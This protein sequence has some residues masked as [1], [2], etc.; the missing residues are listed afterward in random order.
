MFQT[1][2]CDHKFYLLKI[3]NWSAWL[4]VSLWKIQLKPLICSDILLILYYSCYDLNLQ[5][6]SLYL[7]FFFFFQNSCCEQYCIYLFIYLFL[8]FFFYHS[9]SDIFI[10]VSG[11]NFTKDKLNKCRFLFQEHKTIW[12]IHSHLI[13]IGVPVGVQKEKRKGPI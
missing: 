12:N 8:S 2:N 1:F 10:K 7:F 11:S 3:Y 9:P 6:E 4:W 13:I 5:L